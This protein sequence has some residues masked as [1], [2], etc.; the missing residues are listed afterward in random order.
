[1]FNWQLR[2]LR[3]SPSST[4]MTMTF[5]PLL[6]RHRKQ[7]ALPLRLQHLHNALP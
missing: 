4:E 5:F 3:L 2:K 7:Q 6:W 1:M